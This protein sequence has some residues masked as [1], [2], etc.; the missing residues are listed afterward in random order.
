[1]KSSIDS[2]YSSRSHSRN[3][4]L[5][6]KSTDRH[7]GEHLNE[8]DL[9]YAAQAI[10]N[11][12]SKQYL[13]SPD[14]IIDHLFPVTTLQQTKYHPPK[15]RHASCAQLDFLS[16]SFDPKFALSNPEKV[17][18]PVDEFPLFDNFNQFQ[19]R[20]WIHGRFGEWVNTVLSEKQPEKSAQKST[21]NSGDQITWGEWVAFIQD[22]V[23]PAV[24]KNNK[25]MLKLRL[26]EEQ[27]KEK[28][29]E[30]ERKIN[31]E[32]EKV[33]R[34][35]RMEAEVMKAKGAKVSVQGK[36]ERKRAIFHQ[37]MLSSS[38]NHVQHIAKLSSSG[39]LSTLYKAYDLNI[40]IRVY[41]R[42][43]NGVRGIMTGYL[44]AF[45]KHMNLVCSLHLSSTASESRN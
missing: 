15:S 20:V 4:I 29:R 36:V 12:Q 9:E 43:I 27:E 42:K 13:C 38:Y 17:H 40:P 32:K 33:E 6:S 3:R 25:E 44:K 16:S 41:I 37:Q 10:S 2:A 21:S 5:H 28:E 45:D 22:Q 7:Y 19:G 1:M 30:R 31:R 18:Y 26:R 24:R 39:P 34:L 14:V 23:D 11:V 35:K 8:G